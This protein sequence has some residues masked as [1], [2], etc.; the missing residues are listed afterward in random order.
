MAQIH[1]VP[2]H[3]MPKL[4]LALIDC[5]VP[6]LSAKLHIDCSPGDVLPPA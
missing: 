4:L 5:D 1:V 6:A 3:V 2:D